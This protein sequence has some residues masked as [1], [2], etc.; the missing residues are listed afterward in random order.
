MAAAPAAPLRPASEDSDA[1]TVRSRRHRRLPGPKE[2]WRGPRSW[3]IPAWVTGGE[4]RGLVRDLH[5]QDVLAS[6]AGGVL[7]LSTRLA[8]MANCAVSLAARGRLDGRA[9]AAAFAS[10]PCGGMEHRQ[11]R[12]PKHLDDV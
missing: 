8:G 7:S 2:Q 1:G 5:R 11:P 4:R 10:L 12:W 9:A 3:A 6:E